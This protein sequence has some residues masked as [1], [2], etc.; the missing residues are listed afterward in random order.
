MKKLIN[1][2]VLISM[3]FIGLTLMGCFSYRYLLMEL[4]PNAELPVLS[5]AVSATGELDPKYIENQ[6]AIPM[7]GVIGTLEGVEKIETSISTRNARITVS[8]VKGTDIKY[9][10]LKLEEKIKVAAKNLP[11]EFRVQVNKA[12]ASM[13]SS[14]FMNLLVLGDEDVDYVRNVTDAEIAPVLENVDGVAAVTVMGGRQKSIEIILNRERCEALN[15][16]ASQIS[17]LISRNMAEKTFAGSVYDDNKRFFVN[18]TAEYLKTEDLG[19]IVVAPGPVLLKDIAGITFGVKEEESYSRVN[20]KEVIT[21]IV[22]K[23]PQVNV[24]E[25]SERM[26]AEIEKLNRELEQKGVRIQ[27]DSDVAETMSTNI[28]TIVD[29]GISGAILAIFILYLFLRNFRIVTIIAFAIPISVFSSFYFFYLGGI[30]IN[31]LTLTGIALAVGMLLDNS[32]VVMENIFRLRGTGVSAEEASIRG[33]QEV[34]RSI[35]AS[36]LTTITVFLPFLFADNYMLKLIGEHV[37]VSIVATLSLSLIVA[38]LLVPMAINYFMTRRYSRVNFSV[39]SP[40]SRPVQAYLAVLKMALRRP[41]L[42][43]IGSLLLLAVVIALSLTLTLNTLKEVESDSFEVYITSPTGFTLDR[44]DEMIRNYE[45]ELVQIPEIEQVTAKIYAADA[46]I[47][48]KLKE[49]FE[50]INRMSLLE[51]KNKVLGAAQQLRIWNISLEARASSENF[52]GGGGSALLGG[53]ADLLRMLG[54]GSQ[55]EKIVIKGQDFEEMSNLAEYLEY[56]LREQENISYAGVNTSRG[57]PESRIQ[58]DQYLMGV[59]DVT[60]ANVVTELMSFAPENTTQIKYKAGDEEYD[61]QIKD[62]EYVKAKEEDDEKNVQRTLDD[63]RNLQVSNQN[64]ALI[65]LRDFSAINLTRGQGNITR[66]NQDKEL[67]VNYRFNSD[68]NESKQILETARAGIDD[69]IRAVDIPTGLAVEVVHEEN[70][71]DEYGFLVLAALILIFMIL[72]SVF[73]SLSAPIVLMFSIPLAAIGSLLALLLTSNSLMNANVIVGFI[74]LIG[75]VVNNGIIL[76]DYTSLLRR[77]GF[78]K[79]RAL[80]VAGISRIR[81][82]LITTITTIVAML[83]LALGKGEFVSGL[84]APFAI[85][86]IGGLTMSTLLTLVII[87]TLYSGLEDALKRLRTQSVEMKIIQLT[88]MVA[89]VAAIFWFEEGLWWRI[90]YLVLAV[91]LVPGITWFVEGSLKRAKEDIIPKDQEILIEIRNLVKIYGR[92][93]RFM[94]EWTSGLKIRE[95]LGLREEYRTWKDLRVLLWMAPLTVFFYYYVFSYQALVFWA[96]LF[97]VPTWS[98][99]L[100]LTDIAVEFLSAR[101]NR[102]LCRVSGVFRR[103]FYYFFPL[104]VLVWAT[105]HLYG[106]GLPVLAGLLWYAGILIAQLADRIHRRHIDIDRIEGRFRLLR[107]GLYRFATKVPLIGYKK[108]PFKALSSVSMDIRTGMFGLLGPNGAGK[109]TLM[110]I[111]CGVFEQSYGKIFING[112][113]TQRKREE[114]QGLIGYLP[115]EFGTYENLT[116]GQFLEYQAMLKGIYDRETRAKRIR[117]VLEAVHMYENRNKKIGGFS[118]GMKQRI[119]IAQTLLNLPRI[120]VVDEPT[121]GLDPRERIRF[122]NLLV[123]LSRNRIV[124]FSTHIIEDIASSCNQVGVINKGSLRYYGTPGEMANIAREVTW[125]FEIP[126]REFAQLPPDLL[127]VHHIRLGDNIKVRCLSETKPVPGAVRTNPVLEDSYLWLL[128]GVKLANNEEIIT[129]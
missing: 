4:Y 111:I 95:R 71:T 2:R 14:M 92:D 123:E 101:G 105:F 12:P 47:T 54:M 73:E 45:D 99:T 33:T 18:V 57:R 80:M 6:A 108:A 77:R 9:A 37:G 115:Q 125:V 94:R 104:A 84:G 100:K 72:A 90:A 66:V 53:G 114:L 70:E 36:T 82:I 52:Q 79:Q 109:T 5:V 102:G 17:S 15:L 50:K 121:A 11:E 91:I 64:G 86:V 85:T 24:I 42:V 26:R 38:L 35:F 3:L 1:R 65:G 20:G 88:G 40:Y 32:V 7:E 93:G 21:C 96:L 97:A 58:F 60:P 98:L 28:N 48:I 110:R 119:G 126:A 13:V 116:A 19:S 106:G 51:I 63:L 113:D 16:T 112:I 124:V 27:V 62:E 129:Q 87:P 117:E 127:I 75:I 44:T 59:Y 81:P 22:S 25:L 76:I 128:R 10:Y 29:L 122:R 8:F 118:G 68:V 67:V 49:D 46:N 56:Q 89:A 74:I 107:K 34:W 23:S 30:S 41:A 43:V 78:R 69:L 120:L 55:Q 31:T 61:I 103:L 83:P 39:M